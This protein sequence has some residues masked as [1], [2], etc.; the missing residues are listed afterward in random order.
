MKRL[1]LTALLFFSTL[2]ASAVDV[3]TLAPEVVGAWH[4][5]FTTPDGEQ[6]TPVV[7][8]G[9]QKDE[10]VAWYVDK[11]EPQPFKSVAVKE[12]GLEL[13]IVASE[14]DHGATVKM[15]AKPDGNNRCSGK[16]EYTLPG[17]DTGSWDFR[18][19]RVELA[20]L[21]HVSQWKLN[22]TTPD[23]EVHEPTVHIFD[24]AGT[25]YGWYAGD[26]YELLAKDVK[27]TGDRAALSISVKLPDG[28]T[29]NVTFRGKIDGSNV[30]GDAE[31][32]L[33]GSQGSFPFT[34]KQVK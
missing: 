11:D 10:F 28:N 26:E 8:V 33:G 5:S 21:P 22:F 32:E 9:R 31:Y 24:K 12:D 7:V 23:G 29:A 20:K 18:G 17:G 4:L 34:G 13:M 16:A 30:Q 6:R 3:K 14:K 1:A 27:V 25:L 2:S 15:L 19:E